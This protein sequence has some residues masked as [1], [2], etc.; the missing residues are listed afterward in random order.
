MA[1]SM[2][3][4]ELISNNFITLDEIF[5]LIVDDC[6]FSTLKSHPLNKVRFLNLPAIPDNL[7]QITNI[8]V[9]AYEIS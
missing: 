4:W 3:T 8:I 1:N 5:L 9:L 7:F 6:H 2:Q